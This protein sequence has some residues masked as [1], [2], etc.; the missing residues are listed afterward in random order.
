MLALTEL[1]NGQPASAC[2]DHDRLA[3]VSL[4]S[5]LQFQVVIYE[6]PDHFDPQL[7]A[8]YNK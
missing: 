8:T 6:K 5:A 1:A 2:T 3:S 7:A 4:T